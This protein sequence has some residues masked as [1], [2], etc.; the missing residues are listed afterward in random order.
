M[1]QASAGDRIDLNYEQ[2]SQLLKVRPEILKRI[3]LSFATSLTD[4][5]KNL[6][7]ALAQ[8][9]EARMRA[10]LHEIKGTAGNLRLTTI[11]TAENVMHEAVKAG[12]N[13]G[14]LR[15]YFVTLK[16]RVEELQ[17]YLAAE[18]K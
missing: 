1:E 4:K 3:I 2:I 11:T 18:G 5:M 17:R 8:S 14:K 12:E 6:E 16:L 9:D 7:E 15:E 13:P 10:I